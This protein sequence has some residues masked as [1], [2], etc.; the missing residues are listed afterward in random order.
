MA[1][2]A[3]HWRPQPH[4]FLSYHMTQMS[5]QMPFPATQPRLILGQLSQLQPPQQTTPV[6]R[7][8]L[9][10]LLD[11]RVKAMQLTERL[12]QGSKTMITMSKKLSHPSFDV[13][14]AQRR[15]LLWVSSSKYPVMFSFVVSLLKAQ[16]QLIVNLPMSSRHIKTHTLPYRCDFQGCGIG[17]ATQRDLDRHKDAHG[18]IRLYFCPV[19]GC[20]WHVNG[21]KVGFSRRLDNAKRHLKS[22]ANHRDLSVLREDS[23]G[24][25]FRV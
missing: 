18:K 8:S 15:N 22:H 12:E 21:P 20:P 3:S 1:M 17:K 23:Q 19:L 13:P 16:P 14:I 11:P 10:H 25:L 6:L 5:I 24:R 2:M 7:Q 4:Q 9:S